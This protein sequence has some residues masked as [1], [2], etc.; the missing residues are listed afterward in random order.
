MYFYNDKILTNI[1][2]LITINNQTGDCVKQYKLLRD[3]H[4]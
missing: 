2:N 4:R 3:S 1:N